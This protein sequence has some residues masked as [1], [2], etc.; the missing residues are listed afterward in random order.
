MSLTIY[1]LQALGIFM[2]IKGFWV[3][4]HCKQLKTI[5]NQYKN[6]T[7]YLSSFGGLITLLGII[8][9][10]NHFIWGSIWESIVTSIIL[11]ITLKGL[12]VF[13]FPASVGKL[14]KK[15]VKNKTL[16]AFYTFVYITIGV[17]FAL[18]GFNLI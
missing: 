9:A 1:I 2:V 13:F 6:N 8:L 5:T 3:I 18:V 14:M 17:W 7:A 12:W 10:I 4:T 11:L 16:I 15:L